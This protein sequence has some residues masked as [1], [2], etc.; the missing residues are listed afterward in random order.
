MVGAL[1]SPKRGLLPGPRLQA[2]TSRPSPAPPLA[3][4]GLSRGL[5]SWVDLLPQTFIISPDAR[6]HIPHLI[7]RLAISRDAPS[8]WSC[9]QL[10]TVYLLFLGPGNGCNLKVQISATLPGANPA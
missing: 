4:R 7:T 1:D 8:L 9:L 6:A 2:L 10:S 3:P 5:R